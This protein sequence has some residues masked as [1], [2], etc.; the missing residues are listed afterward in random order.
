[1]ATP[2]L[3]VGDLLLS[4]V[5]GSLY[6]QE[7]QSTFHWVVKE[8]G[9]N[10]AITSLITDIDSELLPEYA[11]VMSEDWTSTATY[12]RRLNPSPTRGFEGSNSVDGTVAGDACPPSV[13]A[14]IS[15]YTN[16]PGPRGRGR[17][18]FPAVPDG[19]HAQGKLNNLGLSGY[20]DFAPWLSEEWTTPTGTKLQPILFRAPNTAVDIEVAVVRPILR[21]QRRREVGVGI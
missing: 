13:A 12:V 20:A 11:D 21:S 8:V 4:V 9:V 2:I 19:W 5:K 15:R 18:F 14:V 17:V 3:A 16:N 7:T 1:M 10:I 6:G